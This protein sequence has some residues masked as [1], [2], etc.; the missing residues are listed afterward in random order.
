L[1]VRAKRKKEKEKSYSGRVFL[2][3]L[4]IDALVNDTNT[5]E[6]RKTLIARRGVQA[7]TSSG[8]LYTGGLS[9]EKPEIEPMRP[10]YN[11]ITLPTLVKDPIRK[12]YQ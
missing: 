9:H 6:K 10:G 11:G 3:G 4:C 12:F 5:E 2:L 1:I 7:L 8:Y